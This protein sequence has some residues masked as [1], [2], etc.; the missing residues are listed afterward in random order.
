MDIPTDRRAKIRLTPSDI[1]RFIDLPEGL[2]IRHVYASS[3]P[4]AINLIIEGD[5]LPE[6][7]VDT[8]APYL[9]GHWSQLAVDVPTDGGVKVFRR[10][11]WTRWDEEGR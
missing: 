4:Q 6:T 8:E 7:P 11:E 1:A 10:T 3:D 5:S 9:R 2:T